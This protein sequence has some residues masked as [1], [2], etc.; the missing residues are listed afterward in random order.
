MGPIKIVT[1]PGMSFVFPS[2]LWAL[3]LLAVPLIIHLFN[4]RKTI[5]V[6]FSN[7]RLLRQVKEETTQQRKLKQYLVLVSRLLFIFFLVMAFAQPFLPA[8]EQMASGRQV[9]IYLDN[10]YS[11]SAPA[12]DKIR[13]LDAGL[14]RVRAITAQ[15]PAETRFRFLTN[16]FASFSNNYKTRQE[17]DELTATVRLSPVSRTAAEVKRKIMSDGLA[18]DVFWISDFQQS[19]WGTDA[20]AF[21]SLSVWRLVPVPAL[22]T[23]NVLVDSVYLENPFTVGGEKNTLHVLLRNTGSQPTEGLNVR[24][25]LNGVQAAT[26]AVNLEANSTAR[27]S[28]DLQAGLRNR[29]EGVISFTDFPITFD[30]EFFFA[31]NF[32]QRIRVAEVRA[33]GQENFF[34]R[35]FG[36]AQL[37]SFR[38]MPAGN[39]DLAV[40]GRADLL[41]LNGIT[42]VDAALQSTLLSALQQGRAV[43][44]IPGRDADAN[45]FR[46][47]WP[48]GF[49]TLGNS[50]RELL[51]SPDFRNPFFQDV[52]Q[53]RSA[54]VD[55][56]QATAWWGT[57]AQPLLK[58]KSGATFLARQDNV[59]WLACPLQAE[60]TDFYRH[61]LFVPVMYRMAA[62]GLQQQQPLYT[63]LTQNSVLIKADSLE[64]EA[65]VVLKGAQEVVPAQRQTSEGVLLELPRFSLMPGF[66]RAM[67]GTDTLA[68]LAFDADARESLLKTFSAPE[69]SARLASQQVTVLEADTPQAFEAEVKERF[70]G[71]ALW[72]HALLAALLFLFVEVLLLRFLK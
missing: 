4:F 26:A 20:P 19:T 44:L 6:Y 22:T 40:L 36:N 61:A 50:A 34:E 10:S 56:P 7:T 72:R 48:Q 38:A 45:S 53:E 62:A 42:R 8:R 13:A 64:D 41:I 57:P 58:T 32:T 63:V 1:S 15:Y 51:E 28:F 55:M 21:D 52:F 33:S 27:T 70:M 43:L 39:V 5:R 25:S 2:F 11:M 24:L 66:Y 71:K 30:N 47:V 31:L 68:L 23:A 46:S 60:L 29:N 37:F 54:Q 35:V 9:V 12:G 49:S 65:R 14:A 18:A 16:D 69:V 67:D 3:L 17:V 59:F